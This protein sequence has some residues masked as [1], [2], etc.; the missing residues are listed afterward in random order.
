MGNEFRMSSV[1]FVQILLLYVVLTGVEIAKVAIFMCRLRKRLSCFK[2][3]A[4]KRAESSNAA[5]S[6]VSLAAASSGLWIR[7]SGHSQ[8]K[9]ASRGMQVL[10]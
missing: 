1:L 4:A 9:V 10:S 5:T 2:V 3:P 7:G 8:R 6:R